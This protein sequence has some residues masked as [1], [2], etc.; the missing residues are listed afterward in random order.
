MGVV[1][2]SRSVFRPLPDGVGEVEVGWH[3]HPGSWG[4]GFATEAARAVT[5][6]EV[7]AV[8]R[9]GDRTSMAVCSR[10]GRQ[11]I[12]RFRRWYDVEL[13]TVRLV[14]PVVVE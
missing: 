11:P 8:I 13:E 12:G 4:H 1:L 7:H 14:A 3:L 6:R 10:S 5:D 9:P 2:P